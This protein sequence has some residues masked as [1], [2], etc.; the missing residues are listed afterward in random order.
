[1]SATSFPNLHF[2]V[3]PEAQRFRG[4]APATLCLQECGASLSPGLFN[5]PSS[6]PLSL[7]PPPPGHSSHGCVSVPLSVCPPALLLF[8]ISADRLKSSDLFL[9]KFIQ[10][11]KLHDC[12][13]CQICRSTSESSFSF[14][15]P[16]VNLVVVLFVCI[17]SLRTSCC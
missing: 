9:T 17:F 11:E 7:L 1:M 5:T 2:S 6:L 15:W 3:V 13:Q 16:Q 12:V 14:F 8:L 4:F 10:K